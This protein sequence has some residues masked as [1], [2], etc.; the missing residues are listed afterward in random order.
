MNEKQ[1]MEQEI[2]DLENSLTC[3]SSPIGDWKVTKCMEYEK[4]GKEIPYDFQE[5]SEERQK[6]RDRINELQVQIEALPEE[7]E[8][9]EEVAEEVTEDTTK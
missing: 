1:R 5:L 8:S 6:V 2:R 9:A 3:T 4:M 7:E